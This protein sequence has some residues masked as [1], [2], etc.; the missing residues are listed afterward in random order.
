MN[1]NKEL[2]DKVGK[3]VV[4]VALG[5]GTIGK[6]I[7]DIKDKNKAYSESMMKFAEKKLNENK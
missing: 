6:M 2:L 7:Y 4:Y 1:V 3:G 5:V